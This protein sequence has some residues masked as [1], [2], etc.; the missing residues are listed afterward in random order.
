[1]TTEEIQRIRSAMPEGAIIEIFCDNALTY[2]AGPVKDYEFIWDDTN[3]CFYQIRPNVSAYTQ[4]NSPVEIT[5]NGYSN[6]QRM[7]IKTNL[8]ETI[9]FLTARGYTDAEIKDT[10][11]KLTVLGGAMKNTTHIITENGYADGSIVESD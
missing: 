1:M 4:V 8:K 11:A 6:I 9:E 3:E 5:F 10:I 7:T 2:Y